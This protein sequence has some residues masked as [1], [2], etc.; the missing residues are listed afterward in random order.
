MK[1]TLKAGDK[2]KILNPDNETYREG[3]LEERLHNIGWRI[4]VATG[5]SWQYD[6]M[7][8][9]LSCIEPS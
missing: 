9:P 7:I 3:I 4:R 6:D 5:W 1:D 8:S 2:V